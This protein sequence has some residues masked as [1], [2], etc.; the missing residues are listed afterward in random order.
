M[1]AFFLFIFGFMTVASGT[2]LPPKVPEHRGIWVTRWTYK[3]AEQVNAMMADIADAGFNAVYFQV[4][5]QHDAFYPSEI[6]P[7][8]KELSGTLGQDPGWD[9]LSARYD[10]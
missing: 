1:W 2:A 8:A 5:G 10:R 4:R 7:W 3:S 9:P 6:E